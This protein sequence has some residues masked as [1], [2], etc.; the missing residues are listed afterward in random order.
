MIRSISSL[1]FCNDNRSISFTRNRYNAVARPMRSAHGV[2]RVWP[3][4]PR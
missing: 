4:P 1:S 2:V 3:S